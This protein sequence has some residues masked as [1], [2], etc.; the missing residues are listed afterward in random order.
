MLEQALI[1]RNYGTAV[2]LGIKSIVAL[3]TVAMAVVLPQLV[4]LTVGAQGGAMLLPMYLPV[5]LGACL[6]GVR[7]GVAVGLTSPLFSFLVSSN[8]LQQSMPSVE[9]LPFMM[10]ELAVFALVAGAFSNKIA[11]NAWWSVLAVASATV[12]GRAFYMLMVVAF[13]GV[14][15]VTPQAAWQQITS[16]FIGAGLMVVVVPLLV[17][18]IKRALD[19]K[20]AK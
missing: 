19:A 4:H 9:R 1:K 15:F 18:A 11:G 20:G 17:F 7:W 6:L 10:A 8:L 13:S 12:I 14:A 2:R 16:G 5:L 3:L